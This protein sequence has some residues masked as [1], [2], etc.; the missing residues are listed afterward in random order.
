MAATN[1]KTKTT[2]YTHEGAKAVSISPLQ[3]LERSIMSCLLW[4]KTFYEDGESIV[5]RIRNLV[6]ECKAA[7]VAALIIKAKKDMR[8]RHIPLFLT[9]EL[10]RTK[11]GRAQ[12]S[13]VLPHIIT[14]PDD[15]TELLALYFS[16]NKKKERE[17]A[18]LPNQLKKHLGE[19]FR[20]FDAY[21]LAKYNRENSVKLKDALR[22]THPKPANLEQADLWKQLTKDSLPTP[23]TWEVELSSSKDKKASWERLLKE[24][25]LGG[26]ALLRNIRN[27]KE[28][29]IERGLILEA[30]S[31][32]NAGR[33]LPINFIASVIKNPDFSAILEKKFFDC[34]EKKTK[35]KGSTIV[36][37]DVS[38]SMKDKLSGRSE[39]TRL[40]VA[41]SLAIIAREMFEDIRFFSFSYN[42]VEVPAHRGFGLGMAINNSQSHSGTD[43]GKALKEL[44]TCDRLIVITDEQSQTDVP[45][46]KGYLINVASNQN[47]VGYRQWVHIDG[48][49][50]KVLDYIAAY[51]NDA[52]R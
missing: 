35:L 17:S 44:P 21:Q 27:I 11:E 48:W 14:R 30:I 38:G 6:K 26:L 29:G 37:V 42:L 1:R 32:I 7:D 45:Q 16:D 24:E 15:I 34:F 40:D 18:K 19:A 47:G 13:A 20:K 10:L 25:R 9:R 22:L 23:D 5:S 3:Q 49:S 33:L 51:E 2:E 39:L 50:D 41:Y 4:E 52:A 36:L 12:M 43:L 46:M 8:L 31:K 28:T